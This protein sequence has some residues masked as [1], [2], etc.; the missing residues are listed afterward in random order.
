MDHPN[1]CQLT[2]ARLTAHN[3]S[4][5]TSKFLVCLP[6]HPGSTGK[7]ILELESEF[8]TVVPVASFRGDCLIMLLQLDKHH[9]ESE[10]IMENWDPHSLMVI[11]LTLLQIT[12]M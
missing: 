2:S 11:W 10:G 7:H 1:P 4:R 9:D 8:L 6:A 3:W 5:V 12:T